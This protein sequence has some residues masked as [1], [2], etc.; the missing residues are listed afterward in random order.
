MNF[1]NERV[2]AYRALLNRKKGKVKHKGH[3]HRNAKSADIKGA[4]ELSQEEAE[5]G[6]AY[7]KAKRK[8]LKKE[9]PTLRKIQMTTN[10]LKA[11]SEGKEVKAKEMQ[12]KTPQEISAKMWFH[13][14]RAMKGS[15]GG[16]MMTVQK[17]KADGTLQEST[18]KEETESMIFEETCTNSN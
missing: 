4:M 6:M 10:H 13:I 1:W 2:N 8:Q 18:N 14:G 11:V 9:A 15:R 12:R 7:A 3:C 16:K 5:Q 17:M